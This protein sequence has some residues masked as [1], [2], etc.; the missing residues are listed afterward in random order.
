MLE[1]V[2]IVFI[3]LVQLFIL[4]MP[5]TKHLACQFFKI[6]LNQLV[7]ILGGVF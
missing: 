3:G 1:S 5:N 2:R 4:V 7:M 6:L